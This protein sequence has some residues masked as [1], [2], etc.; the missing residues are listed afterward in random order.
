[1]IARDWPKRPARVLKA[2]W[3]PDLAHE[4]MRNLWRAREDAVNLRLKARQ[5]LRAFLLSPKAGDRS[6]SR[7]HQ[8][9]DVAGKLSVFLH[10]K[11]LSRLG[12]QR[13]L[14]TPR[15]AATAHGTRHE[16]TSP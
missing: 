5:Q 11:V 9:F 8:L 12:P 1:M 15:P 13:N 6:R 14:P 3:V 2:I 10:W 4:A 7:S 16:N